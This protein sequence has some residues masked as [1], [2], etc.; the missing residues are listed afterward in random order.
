M[1]C[2]QDDLPVG[3]V[4]DVHGPRGNSETEYY[5]KFTQTCAALIPEQHRSFGGGKTIDILQ[6][7]NAHIRDFVI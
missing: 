1:K 4:F 3:A 2:D 7:Q 5:Q 6:P